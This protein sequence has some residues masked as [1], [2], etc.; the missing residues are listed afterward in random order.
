MLKL[1]VPVPDEAAIASSNQ[2]CSYRFDRR[3]S[4]RRRATGE[5]MAIF[6]DLDGR[7]LLAR[8]E[9]TDTSGAGLGFLAPLPVEPGMGVALN[10]HGPGHPR[11]VGAIARC[12]RQGEAFRIGAR[13]S[14]IRAA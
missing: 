4:G 6:S 5:A 12:E 7:H 3:R 9:I 11:F 14:A 8:V 10:T 2:D 13:G 1:C